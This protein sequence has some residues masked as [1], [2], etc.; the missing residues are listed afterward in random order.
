MKP[1]IINSLFT[2]QVMS[3]VFLKVIAGKAADYRVNI[4]LG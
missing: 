4:T 3:Y 1:H 2:D